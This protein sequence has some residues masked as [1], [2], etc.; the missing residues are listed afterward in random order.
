MEIGCTLVTGVDFGNIASSLQ[1]HEQRVYKRISLLFE[2][3][4]CM[5]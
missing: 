2:K 5:N 4:T 1:C 3:D